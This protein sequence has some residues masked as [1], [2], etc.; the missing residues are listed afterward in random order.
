MRCVMNYPTHT[1][2]REGLISGIKRGDHRAL[3]LPTRRCC[4][5]GTSG[6]AD[7]ERWRSGSVL[8]ALPNKDEV[9]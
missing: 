3:R 1:Q 7:I 8:M 5:C 4:E 2:I 9:S 6:S